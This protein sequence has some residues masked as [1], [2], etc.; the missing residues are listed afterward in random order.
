MTL[1]TSPTDVADNYEFSLVEK[2]GDL[3]QC[4][5]DMA[6]VHCVSQDY[7]MGTGIAIEFRIRFSALAELWHHNG[8]V[9][10]AVLVVD[11]ERFIFNLITKHSYWQK[12]TY[13]TLKTCLWSLKWLLASNSIGYASN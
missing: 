12:P 3:F 6:L 9:G 11:N 10:E 7:R 5:S 1:L 2:V 13:A 8:Q 4:P